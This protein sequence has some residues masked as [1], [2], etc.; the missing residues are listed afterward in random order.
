[1]ALLIAGAFI[2]IRTISGYLKESEGLCQYYPPQTIRYNL[3]FGQ[4]RS[5]KLADIDLTTSYGQILCGNYETHK[6]Y[7]I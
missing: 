2:T 1:M 7:I 4:Y 3:L 5:Y 6:L